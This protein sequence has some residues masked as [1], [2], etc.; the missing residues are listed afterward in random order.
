MPLHKHCAIDLILIK[1]KKITWTC[2]RLVEWR[3]T[4]RDLHGPMDLILRLHGAELARHCRGI[5]GRIAG[6]ILGDSELEEEGNAS[7]Y[8]H[9]LSIRFVTIVCAYSPLW[10]TEFELD[11]GSVYERSLASQSVA[12]GGVPPSPQDHNEPDLVCPAGEQACGPSRQLLGSASC[13][14]IRWLQVCS[15]QSYNKN[16]EKYNRY[17]IESSNADYEK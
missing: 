12:G 5:R 6:L 3:E 11:R 1:E 9:M 16:I 14:L 7:P 2:S 4:E 10:T 13:T 17:H 8:A 15:T